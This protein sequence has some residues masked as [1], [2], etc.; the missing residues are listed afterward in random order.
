MRS[1]GAAQVLVASRDRWVLMTETSTQSDEPAFRALLDQFDR[2]SV[3]LILAEGFA[4]EPYPKIEVHR[5]S[6]GEPP[7]CWPD[8]PQVIAVASDETLAVAAPVVLLDLNQPVAVV[9][10]LL[11]RLSPS[12]ALPTA[13]V[14]QAWTHR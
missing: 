13:H 7:K 9:Q 2:S 8:D 10:F 5:P 6:Q 12:P 4:R 3:D 11:E 14:R 1:A